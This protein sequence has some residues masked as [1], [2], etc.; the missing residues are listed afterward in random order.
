MVN[1]I[2]PDHFIVAVTSLASCDP[3]RIDF[4]ED[5]VS[6]QLGLIA[7]RRTASFDKCSCGQLQMVN[8][9]VELCP[10]T[11]LAVIIIVIVII[12]IFA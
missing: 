7:K 11:E 6:V 3:C 5:K 12:I 2:L 8:H 10:L 1:Q 4:G 9:A